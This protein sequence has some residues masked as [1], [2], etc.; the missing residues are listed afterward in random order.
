MTSSSWNECCKWAMTIGQRSG[1][2]INITSMGG[3]IHSPFGAWYHATK[4]ALEGW[5]EGLAEEIA[6]LGIRSLV[7]E[8]G[9]MRTMR[10]RR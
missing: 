2:I 8:P 3:K 9:M 6:P 5:M 7:V 4:F 10:D 1:R